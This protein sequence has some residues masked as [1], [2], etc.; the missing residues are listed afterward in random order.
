[1]E[2]GNLIYLS[3]RGTPICMVQGPPDTPVRIVDLFVKHLTKKPLP[4]TVA[5]IQAQFDDYLA[6]ELWDPGRESAQEG[7][8]DA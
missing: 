2:K 1:M 5:E 6:R 4:R 8:Y 7:F 3:F